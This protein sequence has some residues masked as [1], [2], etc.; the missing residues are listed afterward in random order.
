MGRHT[1]LT[2]ELTKKMCKI[3][4][5]GNY[6]K[7]AAAACGICEKTFYSWLEKGRKAK[8]GKY[9]QFL[10]SITHARAEFE[11]IAV[12]E[13]GFK[14]KEWLLERRH[15]DR[16]GRKD[17]LTQDVTVKQIDLVKKWANDLDGKE[18]QEDSTD[19]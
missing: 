17:H 19:S 7:V 15:P 18:S 11:T 9:F 10:Q 2:P 4:K 8:S 14:N 6:S 3:I 1:K 12:K 13:I 5:D 16:W